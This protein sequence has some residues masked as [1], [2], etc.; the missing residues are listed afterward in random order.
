MPLAFHNNMELLILVFL[1]ALPN[2]ILANLCSTKCCC[3]FA[4]ITPS[5]DCSSQELKSFNWSNVPFEKFKDNIVRINLD[6]NQLTELEEIPAGIPIEEL[7]LRSNSLISIQNGALQ[8]LVHLS[9]LDLS[10]NNLT[11]LIRETFQGPQ[12]EGLGTPS[13]LRSLDLSFNNL[14]SLPKTAFEFLIHLEDINL[15]GNPLKL[16]HDQATLT[17]VGSLTK[18]VRMKL[19]QIGIDNVPRHF[20]KGLINLKELDLSRNKLKTV[21]SEIHYGGS[22]LQKLVLDNNPMTS[23]PP[24]SFQDMD[25]LQELSLCNMPKLAEIQ[26]A[27]F[28]G[29]RN[30]S[31]LQ[32]NNNRMLGF[33]DPDAFMDFQ[34]PMVLKNLTLNDNFLRYLPR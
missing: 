10:F 13:P 30:L 12:R 16:V 6:H 18:V 32:I 26:E 20:L 9:K 3:N 1:L 28:V 19:G 2:L 14:E 27:A 7:S 15:S 24:H 8:N 21:P 4:S 11:K 29:L 25:S 5:I 33:I 22:H 34:Y 23:L 31:I 17:A